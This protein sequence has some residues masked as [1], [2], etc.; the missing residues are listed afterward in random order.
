MGKLGRNERCPCGSGK[1]Y[2]RCCE[3]KNAAEDRSRHLPGRFRYE[4]GSYGGPGGYVP[5]ILCY[6]KVEGGPEVEYFCL[7]KTK[8]VFDDED[9]A[10]ARAHRELT[11]AYSLAA[12]GGKPDEFALFLK[13]LGYLSLSDF[14]V[15]RGMS[16]R[17]RRRPDL[18][19]E[20]LT[21]KADPDIEVVSFVTTETGDDLIVSFAILDGDQ[22]DVWSLTLQRTPKYEFVFDDSER[23]VQVSYD[24]NL[25]DDESDRL[26]EFSIQ[27]SEAMIKT[28]GHKYV[29][30]LRRVENEE[31]VEM[32][33]V[34]NL[35]NFDNRFLLR[36]D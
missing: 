9:S 29:L 26:T 8:P 7:V 22:G 18:P 11:D 3:G 6:K 16:A 10:A 20:P 1:K 5:S 21:G 28:T 2:K 13:G 12:Q 35:M 34:L 33:R 15:V 14:R 23:G 36:L 19:E 31:I 17:Q 24:R 27:G 4:S 25:D 32:K 30:E